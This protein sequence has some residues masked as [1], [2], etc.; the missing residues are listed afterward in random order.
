MIGGGFF[1]VFFFSCFLL[2]FVLDLVA[3]FIAVDLLSVFFSLL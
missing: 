3:V 2:P 1:S